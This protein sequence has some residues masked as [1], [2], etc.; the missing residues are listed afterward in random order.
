MDNSIPA[1]PQLDV[2]PA[3]NKNCSTIQKVLGKGDA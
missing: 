3:P 1:I 2:K